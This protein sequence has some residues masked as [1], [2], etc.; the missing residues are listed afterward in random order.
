MPHYDAW[1]WSPSGIEA[2]IPPQLE[3]IQILRVHRP[4]C[5][6]SEGP[7]HSRDLVSIGRA[8]SCPSA[9]CPHHFFIEVCPKHT[10]QEI[11]CIKLFQIL[12]LGSHYK[13]IDTQFCL[14]LM[15]RIILE[16]RIKIVNSF[17]LCLIWVFLDSLLSPPFPK[18]L[19]PITL[20][21]PKLF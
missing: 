17:R 20:P 5:Y 19:L 2:P 9:Q 3:K 11:F 4:I 12:C 6:T 18:H 8:K 7:A 14:Y 16:K 1:P 21:C 10:P 13:Q 15:T